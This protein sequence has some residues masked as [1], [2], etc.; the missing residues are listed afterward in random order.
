MNKIERPIGLHNAVRVIEDICA[1]C[2]PYENT[3]VAPM[4]IELEAGNGQT[5][6]ARYA[7]QM[8]IEYK[9]RQVV[10]LNTFLEFTVDT[11]KERIQFMFGEIAS[12]AQG[13]NN[14]ESVVA[15]DITALGECVHEEQTDYFLN[16]IQDISKYAVVLL[17]LSPSKVKSAAKYNM[18]KDKLMANINDLQFVK[19]EPYTV[20][21]LTQMVMAKID[22]YGID[23]ADETVFAEKLEQIVA[24][25]KLTYAR[26][27]IA[28]AEA[29]A[30]QALV[31]RLT[32]VLSVACA[33]KA[34]PD[35]LKKGGIC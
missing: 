17:Y 33:D 14:Y 28:V 30:N 10:G 12:A 26:E 2:I 21:E 3:R 24:N 35:I 23:I 34:F 9:I 13:V 8:L 6:F 18:L 11:R 19:E 32:A 20:S 5:T 1:N 4:L 25:R 15:M 29:L 16:R 31:S 27:T 22:D 7:A